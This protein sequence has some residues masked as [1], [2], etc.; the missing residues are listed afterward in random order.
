L[1]RTKNGELTGAEHKLL[2]DPIVCDQTISNAKLVAIEMHG[3]KELIKQMEDNIFHLNFQ[4][5]HHG[6]LTIGIN[7]KYLSK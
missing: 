5:Y 6:E 4:I 3:K 1:K 7:K 2:L